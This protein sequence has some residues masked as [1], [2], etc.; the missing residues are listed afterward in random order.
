MVLV[1]RRCRRTS[2]THTFPDPL[3]GDVGLHY[4]AAGRFASYAM[5]KAC[6]RC[7]RSHAYES[8]PMQ[9]RIEVIADHTGLIELLQFNDE[10]ER[11]LRLS[12]EQRYIMRLAIEETIP[13]QRIWLDT[14][15]QKETP[16]TGLAGE[17]PEAVGAVLK[18]LYSDTIGRKGISVDAAKRELLYTEPLQ[19]Y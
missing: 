1:R 16:R 5:M 17:P 15:E 18:T 19:N 13:V 3:A 9:R 7:G 10:A 4:P 2:T 14:A 8:T 11:Q 6:P 12:E